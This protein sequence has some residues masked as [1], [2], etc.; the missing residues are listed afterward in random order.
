[1]NSV[2][3]NAGEWN[4]SPLTVPN[5]TSVSVAPRSVSVKAESGDVVV[6]PMEVANTKAPAMPDVSGATVESGLVT[7]INNIVRGGFAVMKNPFVH[8]ASVWKAVFEASSAD[9]YPSTA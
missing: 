8:M 4:R 3:K 7:K 1:M 6:K 2:E 5:G 9:R